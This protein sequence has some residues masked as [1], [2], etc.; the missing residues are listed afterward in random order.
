MQTAILTGGLATRLNTLR[1]EVP[2]SMIEVGGKP[3]LQYQIELLKKNNIYDIILCVGHL[4][5]QI[6]VYF[7]DG[8]QFGVNIKYS[9]E[10]EELLGTGGALKKASPLLNDTFIVMYGDSY[11]DFNYNSF[12]ELFYQSQVSALMAVYKNNDTLDKSNVSFNNGKILNYDK[13]GKT[14]IAYYI[15]YGATI[16]SKKVLDIIPNNKF[17]DL[18]DVFNYLSLKNTLFGYEVKNRFYEIGSVMGLRDF[19]EY[20]QIENSKLINEGA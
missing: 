5:D 19:E 13:R 2:K 16:L 14:K 7:G 9:W 1:L 18:A 8:S 12:I 10:K 11:L 3:F 15:D 17:Y 6:I 20:M 4:G